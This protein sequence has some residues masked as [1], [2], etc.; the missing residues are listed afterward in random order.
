MITIVKAAALAP[1]RVS[2][3]WGDGSASTLDLATTFALGGVFTP[4]ADPAAFAAVKVGR[5]GRSLCWLDPDGDEVDLCADA[6]W[7][8]AHQAAVAA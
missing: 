1:F 7:R 3:T 4:L 2:V 6:L 5:R 8:L